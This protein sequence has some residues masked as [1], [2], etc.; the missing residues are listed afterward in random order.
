MSAMDIITHIAGLGA[1]QGP[2]NV[3]S[4]SAPTSANTGASAGAAA[5]FQSALQGFLAG[6]I[7]A[8]QASAAGLTGNGTNGLN[9]NGPIVS[10]SAS[11]QSGAQNNLIAGLLNQGAAAG[12]G[13]AAGATGQITTADL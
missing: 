8:D 4:G 6:A 3:P 5:M 7:T 10:A 13:A 11:N 2:G 9:I 1:P 12:N